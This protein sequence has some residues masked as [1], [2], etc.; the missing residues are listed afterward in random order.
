MIYTYK[1]YPTARIQLDA[2]MYSR[3]QLQDA[4]CCIDALNAQ[5]KASMQPEKEMKCIVKGCSNHQ[6][7]GKFVDTLC[8]PCHTMLT[9]GKKMP[10]EAWFAK[11]WVGLTGDEIEDLPKGGTLW[12][13]IRAAEAILKEKNK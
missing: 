1:T 10:S 13:I 11:P 8:S 6:G 5:A 9:Q 2:G 7:E 3:Q 4:I 12:E